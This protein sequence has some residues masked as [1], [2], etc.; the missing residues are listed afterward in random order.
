MVNSR[1]IR[2]ED[3]EIGSR[4]RW[5]RS[6]LRTTR[7]ELGNVLG[8]SAQQILK[9]EIGQSR[10]SA[11]QLVAITRAL[12]MPVTRLFGED[13]AS[14]SNPDSVIIAQLV[15]DF[16]TLDPDL[17]EMIVR[18]TRTLAL[19]AGHGSPAAEA[20]PENTCVNK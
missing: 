3:R 9:Y 20:D 13:A 8:V 4:L 10:I 5:M 14:L 6:V 16:S 11:G 7:R 19:R 1:S 2:S 17:Q 15:H 12:K 18:L